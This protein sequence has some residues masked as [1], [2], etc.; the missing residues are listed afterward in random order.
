MREE[1]RV[2]MDG[3]GIDWKNSEFVA[4]CELCRGGKVRNCPIEDKYYRK[5]VTT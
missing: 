2:L 5:G 3:V 4:I 1:K